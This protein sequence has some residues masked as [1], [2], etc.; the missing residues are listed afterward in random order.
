MAR[1]DRLG[2]KRKVRG[3]EPSHHRRMLI[4]EFS[5]QRFEF[6][7]AGIVADRV[8]E[9]AVR[10][11]TLSVTAFGADDRVVLIDGSTFARLPKALVC[12]A[13]A[14]GAGN[15]LKIIIKVEAIGFNAAAV[16]SGHDVSFRCYDERWQ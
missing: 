6:G 4:A 5:D 16:N 1:G 2:D 9:V 11:I 3:P 13:I 12:F 7:I 15:Y 10:K 8:F 14:L